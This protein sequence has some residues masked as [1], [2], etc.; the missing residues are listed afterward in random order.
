MKRI[1]AV[2]VGKINHRNVLVGMAVSKAGLGQ[3]GGLHI[4]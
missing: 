1:I 2:S 4:R 3:R